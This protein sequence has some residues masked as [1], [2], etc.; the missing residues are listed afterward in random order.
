MILA[1]HRVALNRLAASVNLTPITDFT[2][3][4]IHDILRYS[5]K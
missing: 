3:A 5:Q 4:V 1:K 2:T